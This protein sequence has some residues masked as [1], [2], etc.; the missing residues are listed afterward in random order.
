MK[1]ATAGQGELACL[2]LQRV[3]SLNSTC[4]QDG[5]AG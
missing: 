2:G 4:L 3:V 5:M 1:Q